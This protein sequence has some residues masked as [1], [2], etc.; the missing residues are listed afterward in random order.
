MPGLNLSTFNKAAYFQKGEVIATAGTAGHDE[1]T[2]SYTTERL[3]YLR[4]IPVL[5]LAKSIALAKL[6]SVAQRVPLLQEHSVVSVRNEYGAIGCTPGA[7]PHSGPAK[8][9]A[10][11]QLF[12]NGELWSVC[13]SLII[14]DRKDR[15][16]YIQL[17]ALAPQLFE[18]AYF[19]ALHSLIHF[20]DA[21]LG[22]RSPWQ[23]ELGVVGTKGLHVY[24]LTTGIYATAPTGSILKPE[25]IYRMIL[26]DPTPSVVDDLLLGF[27]TKVY[28]A[29]GLVRPQ[30]MFG[31]PP[32]RQA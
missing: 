30:N 17:P 32:N 2:Y 7:H 9:N 13:A 29:A 5:P 28:D 12:E 11:T 14:S 27:F 31:F 16:S 26:N 18:Q 1:I 4:L 22:L 23:V 10:S 15:P 3:C 19:N 6:A 21:R 24:G 8:L 25:I 20:A